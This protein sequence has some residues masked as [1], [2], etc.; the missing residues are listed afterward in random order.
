MNKVKDNFKIEIP[1]LN[2]LIKLIDDEDEEIYENIKK[3]FL[4]YGEE[5]KNFLSEFTKSED[6]L[7]AERSKEIIS[8][9]DFKLVEN[10]IRE[11]FLNKKNLL[12]RAVF[13]I[14]EYG[15]PNVDFDNYKMIIDKMAFDI[16][17]R[18]ERKIR[19]VSSSYEK[20]KIIN[21]YLF[22]RKKFK[23]NTENYNETDN[24]Y[25]NKVID[26]KMGIPVSLS[27]LYLLIA[28]RLKLP[29]YGVNLPSHFIVKYQDDKEEL[30]IDPFNEGI[31]ISR[32][33]AIKFLKQLGLSEEDC[34]K[35]SFLNNASERDIVKR[36]IN[37][38][39]HI[40]EKNN[41]KLKAGKLK[42]LLSHFELI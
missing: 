26:R 33:E 28:N 13:L 30:F 14:S 11:L 23:G 4:L 25:I 42:Q 38:L 31:V 37:N 6:L 34:N 21:D 7:I 39:I 32:K 1:E 18:I 3:R 8:I 16:E 36:Y 29:I 12:E 9:L 10:K 19:K 15:Y 40:Y 35:I 20:I 17:S 27:I 5:S 2:H 41:E 22:K 24:L